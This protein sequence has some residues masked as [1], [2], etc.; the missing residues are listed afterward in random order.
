M[1]YFQLLCKDRKQFSRLLQHILQLWRSI[2][3][4]NNS[5]NLMFWKSCCF[6]FL[7]HFKVSGMLWLILTELDLE[8]FFYQK[9]FSRS[10]VVISFMCALWNDYYLFFLCMKLF[11]CNLLPVSRHFLRTVFL[12]IMKP[13]SHKIML[14]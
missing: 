5:N 12:L 11:D 9:K 4:I 6:T 1:R 8:K 13:Y 7:N 2:I 14:T 10:F 3:T